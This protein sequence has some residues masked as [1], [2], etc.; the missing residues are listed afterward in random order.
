MFIINFD[1]DWKAAFRHGFTKGLAAPVTLFH[2]EPAP[3]FEIY[4]LPS[5]TKC[6]AVESFA[7][8]WRHI[9]DDFY[10]VIEKYG[11]NETKQENCR[12][13]NSD[14]KSKKQCEHW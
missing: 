10:D 14:E 9:G 7:D 2:S 13:G 8:D 11:P 4:Y 3:E 6:S 1:D 5:P 12:K